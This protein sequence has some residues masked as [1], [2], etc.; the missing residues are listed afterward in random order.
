MVLSLSAPGVKFAVPLLL[1]NKT[2]VRAYHY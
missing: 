1:D 2:G